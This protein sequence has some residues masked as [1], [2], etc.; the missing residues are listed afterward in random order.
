MDSR[1]EIFSTLARGKHPRTDEMRNYIDVTRLSRHGYLMYSIG[2]AS[3]GTLDE[4]TKKNLKIR[5]NS[6]NSET[7]WYWDDTTDQAIYARLLVHLG[8]QSTAAK[9]ISDLME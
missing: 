4:T 1:A 2:L 9:I 6:R 7:Y 3:L 5:M 8:E